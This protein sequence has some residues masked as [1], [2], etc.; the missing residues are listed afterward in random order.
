MVSGTQAPMGKGKIRGSFMQGGSK[1]VSN[2]DG[3]DYHHR[4]SVH[5]ENE[6]LFLRKGIA[7]IFEFPLS[8]DKPMAMRGSF[9]G[10]LF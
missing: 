2:T 10:T 7:C 4:I 9:K 5:L 8:S 6:P 3:W 1:G